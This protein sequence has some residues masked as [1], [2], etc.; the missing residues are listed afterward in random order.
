MS[1]RELSPE[2]A[3]ARLRAGA[4]LIDVR[5]EHERALGMAEGARGIDR[6]QL[7]SHPQTHLPDRD[8]EIL[9]ICQSG[10]RSQ[11]AAQTLAMSGYRKLASVT[12]G[13]MA[14]EAAALPMVRP[15]VRVRP[16]MAPEPVPVICNVVA[17]VIT[18]CPSMFD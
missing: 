6:V 5:E 10:Q 7:E 8:A 12:G 4:L 15:D 17:D 13:T 14:W 18:P 2:Q 16:T 3:L 1:V 9:L 11:L